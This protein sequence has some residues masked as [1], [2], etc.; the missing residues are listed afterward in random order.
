M[1]KMSLQMNTAIRTTLDPI[2]RVH[3]LLDISD[4]TFIYNFIICK[5]LKQPFIVG[6]DLLQCYK[7]GVDWHAYGTLF[8]KNKDKNIATAMRKG[9]QCQPLVVLLEMP[10]ADK[11]AGNAIKLLS[12]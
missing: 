1:A 9:N 2:D 12:Y 7:F 6:L 10:V 5:K 4:H 3:L 11:C 8:L